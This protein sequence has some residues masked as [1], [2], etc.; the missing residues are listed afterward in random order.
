MPVLYNYAHTLKDLG[1]MDAAI[2]A[3]TNVVA[4]NLKNAHAN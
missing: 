4:T 1:V 2:T 3:Y